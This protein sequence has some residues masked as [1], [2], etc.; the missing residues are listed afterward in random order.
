MPRE[1]VGF[2]PSGAGIDKYPFTAD[3]PTSRTRKLNTGIVAVIAVSSFTL[4]LAC[5][6]VVLFVL[7][8]R[9]LGRPPIVVNPAITQSIPKRSGAI[10]FW[11]YL[12]LANSIVFC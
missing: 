1:T 10:I 4:I 11:D 8:W 3:V 9:K 2:G 5:V 7:K 6:G 12:V